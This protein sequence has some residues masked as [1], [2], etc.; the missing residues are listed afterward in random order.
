LYEE[1]DANWLNGKLID[2][3]RWRVAKEKYLSEIQIEKICYDISIR[4]P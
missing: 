2:A 1:A 3:E 4:Y